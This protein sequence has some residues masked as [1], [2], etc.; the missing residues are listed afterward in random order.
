[1]AFNPA[2]VLLLI[3]VSRPFLFQKK[4]CHHIEKQSVK[5]T[6]LGDCYPDGYYPCTHTRALAH[7]ERCPRLKR[8]EHCQRSLNSWAKG[9]FQLS[10]L[11]HGSTTCCVAQ[12]IYFSFPGFCCP[13]LKWIGP[14]ITRLFSLNEMIGGLLLLTHQGHS[15]LLLKQNMKNMTWFFSQWLRWSWPQFS[16]IVFMPLMRCAS[17][18]VWTDPNN[19]M[20]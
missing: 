14:Y 5:T 3:G 11:P 6:G 18:S 4:K 1:M 19:L 8:F 20:L 7:T 15:L 9:L 16:T 13:I 17:C 10:E 12:T 2:S